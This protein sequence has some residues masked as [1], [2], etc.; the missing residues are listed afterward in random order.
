MVTGQ[1]PLK[2]TSLR[3]RGGIYGYNG[4][5]ICAGPPPESPAKHSHCIGKQGLHSTKGTRARE[6]N[7]VQLTDA[8]VL[9]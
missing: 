6:N 4:S 9:L 7:S 3:E 1:L 2:C 8:V 5:D